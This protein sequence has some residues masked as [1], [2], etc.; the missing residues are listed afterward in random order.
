MTMRLEYTRFVPWGWGLGL[1]VVVLRPAV[2]V[3]LR[4]GRYSCRV[5]WYRRGRHD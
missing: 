5:I 4:L 2:N 1:D 3:Y